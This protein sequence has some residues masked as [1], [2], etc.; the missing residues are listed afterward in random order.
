MAKAAEAESADDERL[1]RVG[2]KGYSSPSSWIS[3]PRGASRPAFL[4]LLMV[5]DFFEERLPFEL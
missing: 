1:V 3:A 2:G 5:A 4:L